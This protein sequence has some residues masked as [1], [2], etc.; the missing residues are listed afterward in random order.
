MTQTP[1]LRLLLVDDEEH[2][3]D[4]MAKRLRRRGVEVTTALS[5]GDALRLLRGNEFDVMLL[6]LKM[7]D[8]S[9]LDV[10][11][12]VRVLAPELPVIM[13]T[14]HGSDQAAQEGATYGATEYL[15]KPCDLETLLDKLRQ[16]VGQG[17][18]DGQPP[19]AAF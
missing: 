17:E 16:V 12:M 8:L 4:V 10:L 14:G 5:G 15:L 1:A 19:S 9:G 18:R 13:L 2:F 11:K 7:E 6:D 3:V